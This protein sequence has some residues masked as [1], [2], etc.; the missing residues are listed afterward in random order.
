MQGSLRLGEPRLCRP[1]VTHRRRDLIRGRRQRPANRGGSGSGWH[2][3]PRLVDARRGLADRHPRAGDLCLR[4]VT[5]GP[6][7]PTP[8]QRLISLP[9][10]PLQ[11]PRV[12][13]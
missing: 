12:G 2:R 6:R 4:A 3:R 7:L 1:M 11:R 10:R 13:P 8:R 5:P 9:L